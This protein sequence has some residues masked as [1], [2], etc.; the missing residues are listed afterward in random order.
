MRSP[1]RARVQR[2]LAVNSL[3]NLIS[4]AFAQLST[5]LSCETARV[6]ARLRISRALKNPETPAKATLR[7]ND[8]AANYESANASLFIESIRLA[9]RSMP[10]FIDNYTHDGGVILTAMKISR[11]FGAK[12]AITCLKDARASDHNRTSLTT[13]EY[14]VESKL[15]NGN[16]Q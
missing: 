13:G 16:W 1:I 8:S 10:R 5:Q 3:S 4:A 2:L 15:A 14:R 9:S 6:P 12:V 7:E 11:H